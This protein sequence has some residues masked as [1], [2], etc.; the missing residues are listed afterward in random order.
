MWCL[1]SSGGYVH[2]FSPHCSKTDKQWSLRSRVLLVNSVIPTSHSQNYNMFCDK[3]F[4]SLDVQVFTM[5]KMR[6]LKATGA[7]KETCTRHCFLC[8]TDTE[9]GIQRLL[10]LSLWK[11]KMN[12]FVN[13]KTVL[14]PATLLLILW[15]DILRSP[16]EENKE[17]LFKIPRILQ[18][19][20]SYMWGVDLFDK[21]I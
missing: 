12:Y 8:L 18:E 16:Q 5:L 19:C 1:S 11:S 17:N 21:Q 6:N 9:E 7:V 2:D 20:N 10:W 3:C 13:W 15:L 14:G 4:A